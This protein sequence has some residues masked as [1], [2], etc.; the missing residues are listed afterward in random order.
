MIEAAASRKKPAS[1][2]SPNHHCQQQTKAGEGNREARSQ[3]QR[4]ER[5]R[6]KRSAK[7]IGTSGRTQGDRIESSAAANASASAPLK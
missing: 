6:G 7:T 5:V 1:M 3:R 4:A 2:P